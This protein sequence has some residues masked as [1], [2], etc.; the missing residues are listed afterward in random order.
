MTQHPIKGDK[1]YAIRRVYRG[2][3]KADFVAYFCDEMIGAGT[4]RT[5]AVMVCLAHCDK[6][7]AV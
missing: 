3:A 6:R 2:R 1:R 7:K 5:D 4:H